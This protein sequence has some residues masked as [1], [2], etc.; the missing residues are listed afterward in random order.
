MLKVRE[1]M[2]EGCCWII[3]NGGNIDIWDDPWIPSIPAMKPEKRD[4]GDHGTK[5]VKDL[6][7][8]GE[9]RT[10]STSTN[11]ELP[12]KKYWSVRN[13]PPRIQMFGW[14]MLKNGL[15]VA[16]N[17]KKHIQGI[18]DDCRL[19]ERHTECM[20]HLFLYCQLTQ[21]VLFA[22][23]LSLRIG[24]C[25]NLSVKDIIFMW[26]EEG[27][28]YAKLGMGLCVLWAIWKGRN[29]VV[30]NK[31]KFNIR[32]KDYW[33]PP[34]GEKIKIN[35]DGAAGPKG[36]ACGVIA[37]E[38][39]AKVQGCQNK[40]IDYCT[41]VEAEAYSAGLAVE[42]GINKGFRDI[43]L[44]GDSLNVI[45]ALRYKHYNSSWRIQNTISSIR[46][47]LRKFNSVEFR[48]IRKNANNV[49][50][51]L[52]SLAASTHTSNVWLSSPPLSIVHLIEN[53]QYATS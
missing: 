5:K 39:R 3:V 8:Q 13:I 18:N 41:A 26:L 31:K 7:I 35:F 46:D 52:A 19:C 1:E 10:P 9:R 50:H 17:I 24:E 45:N 27:G 25:P 34:E 20:E 6:I 23:P 36:F 30:F 2:R 15:P 14:R 28:D 38:K 16:S 42:L 44:E 37:R 4:N 12:W 43:I 49:A 11:N 47:D 32:E 33:E 48:I 22:S 53:E 40:I 21:A 51:N 29:D